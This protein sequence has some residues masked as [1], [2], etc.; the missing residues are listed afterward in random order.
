M[1][2]LFSI[3]RL[4]ISYWAP[5]SISLRGTLVSSPIHVPT[6]PSGPSAPITIL[7]LIWSYS[8]LK[9]WISTN[10]ESSSHFIP[11]ASVLS[12]TS[13][14][15]RMA[16]MVT[17]LSNTLR[18]RTIPV[19]G[20]S[21]FLEVNHALVP[22]GAT[23]RAPSIWRAIHRSS[24]SRPTF[25]RTP[26]IMPSPHLLGVPISDFL[27]IIKVSAPF[28]LASRAAIEPAGPAPIIKTSTSLILVI[29]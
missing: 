19:A 14:P 26:S 5:D 29:K 22:S 25:S 10:K 15:L 8:F 11:V 7:A 16:S 24:T 9:L 18:S 3:L 21:R 12:M 23:R 20:F 1:V 28:L 4:V 27:S 2:S 17:C 13:A 6:R